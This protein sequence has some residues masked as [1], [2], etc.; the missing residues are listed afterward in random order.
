VHFDPTGT[1]H[2]PIVVLIAHAL[3]GTEKTARAAGCDA[4]L[5]KPCVPGG[6]SAAGLRRRK[7]V[8][9]GHPDTN[10]DKPSQRKVCL[11]WRAGTA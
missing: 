1:Q 10:A 11:P 9:P 7:D 3:P 2:I 5:V 8:R 4:F 6:W